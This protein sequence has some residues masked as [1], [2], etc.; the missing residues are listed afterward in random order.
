M[1]PKITYRLIKYKFLFIES[2]FLINLWP[3]QICESQFLI[4]VSHILVHFNFSLEI[5]SKF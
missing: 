1:K 3:R 2:R 4:P 5:N